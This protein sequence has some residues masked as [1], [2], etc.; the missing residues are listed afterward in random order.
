MKLK[1]CAF[2]VKSSER[3]FENYHVT[4]ISSLVLTDSLLSECLGAVAAL[5]LQTSTDKI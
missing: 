5:R 4:K 1:I 3:V 2:F